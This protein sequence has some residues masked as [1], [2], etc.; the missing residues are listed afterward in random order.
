MTRGGGGGGGGG[1]AGDEGERRR[2]TEVMLRCCCLGLLVQSWTGLSC[3]T[4][5]LLQARRA[6]VTH[7]HTRIN[8]SLSEVKGTARALY[9]EKR[10]S[11]ASEHEEE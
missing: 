3:P 5:C 11:S 7:T 9:R 8:T 10:A 4:R 2:N 1:R 6:F